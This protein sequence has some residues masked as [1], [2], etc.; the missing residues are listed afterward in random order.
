LEVTPTTLE[1]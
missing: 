1:T